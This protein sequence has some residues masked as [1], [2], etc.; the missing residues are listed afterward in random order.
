MRPLSDK[1]EFFVRSRVAVAAVHKNNDEVGNHQVGFLPL[2]LLGLG[3]ALNLKEIPE[4]FESRVSGIWVI[5]MDSQ[6]ISFFISK[7]RSWP[8]LWYCGTNCV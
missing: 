2:C 5:F 1:S 4:N 6:A 8:R 7:P 3:F